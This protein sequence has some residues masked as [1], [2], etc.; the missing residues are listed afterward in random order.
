L[1]KES[2]TVK[3]YEITEKKDE[4]EREKKRD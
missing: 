1:K 4:E 3:A 2:G